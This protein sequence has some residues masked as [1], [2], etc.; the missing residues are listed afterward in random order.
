MGVA[1]DSRHRWAQGL[2]IAILAVVCPRQILFWVSGVGSV[3]VPESVLLW[4]DGL[5]GGATAIVMTGGQMYLVHHLTGMALAAR[6]TRGA[7][8]WSGSWRGRG[9]W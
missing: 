9:C 2:M 3:E 8:P 6:S 4:A 7:F 5:V 1:I